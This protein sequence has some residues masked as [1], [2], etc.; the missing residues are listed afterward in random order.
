MAISAFVHITAFCV[1]Q[2]F[3]RSM[4]HGWY[5]GSAEQLMHRGTSSLKSAFYNK[6]CGIL[7]KIFRMS[8]FNIFKLI[9]GSMKY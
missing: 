7:Q 8:T 4:R 1:V 5:K 3:S 2:L 6:N 9:N